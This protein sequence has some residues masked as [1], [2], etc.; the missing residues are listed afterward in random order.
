MRSHD[1]PTPTRSPNF[2]FRPR[3]EPVRRLNSRWR[4]SPQESCREF[5]PR[6]DPS[7]CHCR[8]S[9]RAPKQRYRAL[10]RFEK[11][12]VLLGMLCTYEHPDFRMS[13]NHQAAANSA[14]TTSKYVLNLF[15][16]RSPSCFSAPVLYH[17]P[18]IFALLLVCIEIVQSG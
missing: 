13:F 18:E 5:T 4:I 14:T 15:D 1:A 16:A 8:P 9:P 6:L 2:F 17:P 10:P 7:A 3:W 11:P 12:L